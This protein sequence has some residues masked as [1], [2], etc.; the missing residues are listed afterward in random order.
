MKLKN[1]FKNS[2]NVK[3]IKNTKNKNKFENYNKKK[4]K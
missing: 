1:M 4:T 3:I 2:N